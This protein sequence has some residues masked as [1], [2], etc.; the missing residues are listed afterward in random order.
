MS[1]EDERRYEEV[2]EKG[3]KGG[4]IEAI[5]A[6]WGANGCRFPRHSMTTCPCLG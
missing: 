5:E 6:K 2:Q 4:D 3:I 1:R